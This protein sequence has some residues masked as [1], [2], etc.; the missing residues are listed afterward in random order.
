MKIGCK[1]TQFYSITQTFYQKSTICVHTQGIIVQ[2]FGQFFGI[3]YTLHLFL[4]HYSTKE[5][6]V[7]LLVITAAVE[8]MSADMIFG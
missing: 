1:V 4:L 2:L 7:A 5:L 3:F 6:T 8:A